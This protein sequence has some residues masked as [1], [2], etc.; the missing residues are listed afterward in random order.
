MNEQGTQQSDLATFA[1][2]LDNRCRKGTIHNSIEAF[3][4]EIPTEK[5][6]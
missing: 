1:N 3:L 5:H 2:F 4:F 6:S